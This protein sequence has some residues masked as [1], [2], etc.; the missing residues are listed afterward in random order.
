[1]TEHVIADEARRRLW[2]LLVWWPIVAIVAGAAV[3]ALGR[4]EIGWVLSLTLIAVV[5]ATLPIGLQAEWRA[6][7][8][9]AASSAPAASLTGRVTEVKRHRHSP[10]AVEVTPDDVALAT[11]RLYVRGPAARS[12]EVGDPVSADVYDTGRQRATVVRSLRDD[13]VIPG[14]QDPR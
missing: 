2:Q 13:R 10:T 4:L 11:I 14:L 7:R 12:A 1:M 6:W 8:R 5:L 3:L 9:A